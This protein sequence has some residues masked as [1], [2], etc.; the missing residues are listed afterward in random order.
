MLRV[1]RLFR[2]MMRWRDLIPV[3][4]SVLRSFTILSGG[5]VFCHWNACQL[6]FV[7]ELEGFPEESW[8]VRSG[9]ID[10]APFSQ[11]THCLLASLCHMTGQGA[12]TGAFKPNTL[13]ELWACMFSVAVGVTFYTFL[14]G[15]VGTILQSQDRELDTAHKRVDKWTRFCRVNDIPGHLQ[16]QGFQALAVKSNKARHHVN[17]DMEVLQGLRPELR[18]EVVM[19]IKCNSIRASPIF[20]GCHDKMVEALAKCLL[21]QTYME[22]EVIGWPGDLVSAA[23]F[24]VQGEVQAL[25]EEQEVQYE[26]A[27]GDCFGEECLLHEMEKIHRDPTT[28]HVFNIFEDVTELAE[29]LTTPRSS[30]EAEPG[31]ASGSRKAMPPVWSYRIVPGLEGAVCYVLPKR[32]LLEAVR[33]VPSM[34]RSHEAVSQPVISPATTLQGPQMSS[35]DVAGF[36]SMM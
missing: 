17:E 18:S 7:A 4:S 21:R 2:Y 19:C 14:L 33:S 1:P 15:M 22:G 12:E 20:N 6:F 32:R 35:E 25:D 27:H 36:G 3:S 8:L 28:A 30:S 11:Y 5:L 31:E 13:P 16:K 26:L 34:Y 29:G 10:D 9:L 23:Y 24:V